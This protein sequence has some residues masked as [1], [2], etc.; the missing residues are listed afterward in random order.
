[1]GQNHDDV[2]LEW[3]LRDLQD[4]QYIGRIKEDTVGWGYYSSLFRKDKI[5][6]TDPTLL[7]FPERHQNFQYMQIRWHRKMPKG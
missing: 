4:S 2:I 6:L 3:S 5:L 1:M 7:P